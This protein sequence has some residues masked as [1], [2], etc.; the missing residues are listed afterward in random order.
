MSYNQFLLILLC[1]YVYAH[2]D[3]FAGDQQSSNEPLWIHMLCATD[4]KQGK[5]VMT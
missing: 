4:L 5:L 3:E 2:Q 1:T